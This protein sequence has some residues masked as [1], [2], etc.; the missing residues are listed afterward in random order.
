MVHMVSA[1]TSFNGMSLGQV[2]VD[3]KSNEITAI[4]KL[5]EVLMLTGCIVTIDAVGCQRDIAA[6]IKAGGADYILALKGNQSSLHDQAKILTQ[7]EPA[8]QSTE[9]NRGH[10]RIET[11]KCSVFTD[12]SCIESP[13][14]WAGL[15]SIIRVDLGLPRIDGHG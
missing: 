10:G 2:K 6:K 5:L 1:W 9:T 12:L 8:T 14:R 4:P 11:R 13:G 15:N 3:E 7:S